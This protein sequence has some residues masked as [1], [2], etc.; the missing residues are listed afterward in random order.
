MRGRGCDGRGYSGKWCWKKGGVRR[1]E[2]G[3][4]G[5]LAGVILPAVHHANSTRFVPKCSNL[6]PH[7]PCQSQGGPTRM[8]LEIHLAPDPTPPAGVPSILAASPFPALLP[9][10]LLPPML[11]PGVTGPPPPLPHVNG[12]AA[13]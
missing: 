1:H 8:H 9:G 7:Y 6:G 2:M 13:P 12:V 11:P 3:W 4:S 5:G 10:V